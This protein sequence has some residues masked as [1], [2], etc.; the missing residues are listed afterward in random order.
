MSFTCDV[1]FS[2]RLNCSHILVLIVGWVSFDMQP[3]ILVPVCRQGTLM[4]MIP[5]QVHYRC[6]RHVPCLI[7]YSG[8][9]PLWKSS[10][11]FPGS[12]VL[13]LGS[14]I[15]FFSTHNILHWRL[16]LIKQVRLI[17]ISVVSIFFSFHPPLVLFLIPI[18][19]STRL[20]PI[21]Y[22]VLCLKKKK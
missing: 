21:S 17:S 6:V 9:L 14:I 7:S 1:S 10:T 13:V 2:S 18:S 22:V 11:N 4:I 12:S 19:A 5:W 15:W 8:P 20:S 16:L 3:F